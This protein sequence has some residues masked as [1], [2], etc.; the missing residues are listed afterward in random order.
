M[1]SLNSGSAL[2]V[3]LFE[4]RRQ[5]DLSGEDGAVRKDEKEVLKSLNVI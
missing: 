4:I 5:F 3:L 2:S 1:N